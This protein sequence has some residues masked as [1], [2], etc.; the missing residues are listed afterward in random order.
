[1]ATIQDALSAPPPE[2]AGEPVANIPA[3][4]RPPLSAAE[5]VPADWAAPPLPTIQSMSELETTTTTPDPSVLAPPLPSPARRLPRTI[6]RV[7]GV[8]LRQEHSQLAAAHR[9]S[10]TASVKAF[11]APLT[12]EARVAR[13]SAQIRQQVDQGLQDVVS[14]TFRTVRAQAQMRDGE[15]F[16]VRVVGPGRKTGSGAGMARSNSGLSISGTLTRK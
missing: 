15:L 11:F 14:E 9:R 1:M 4:D 6:S 7:D 10:S 12:F 5:E 8:A 16:Q 2:W 3:D 13:P